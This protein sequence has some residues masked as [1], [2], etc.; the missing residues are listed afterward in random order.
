MINLNKEVRWHGLFDRSGS[1]GLPE[2]TFLGEIGWLAPI[3]RTCLI[4]SK[5][6]DFLFESSVVADMADAERAIA[7]LNERAETLVDTEALARILLRAES[8]ASS[9]IEGLEIGVRRLLE[10]NA[11][12]QDGKITSD[13]N[14]E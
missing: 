6:D 3:W 1:N 12:A 8:I 9:R 11:A 4:L 14:C 13:H 5:A 10:A 2:S 7:W